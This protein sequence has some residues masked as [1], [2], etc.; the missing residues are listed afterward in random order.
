MDPRRKVAIGL[1]GSVLDAGK[2]T[3]RWEKWRPTVA[4]CQYE[5][6]VFDRLELLYQPRFTAIFEQL[7]EDIR[8][9]SPE[10]TVRGHVITCE[11][12]WDFQ[13]VYTCLHDFA[14]AYP[15]DVDH[16]E[17]FVHITTGTHVAQIC[18]SLLTEAR[19]FPAKLFQAS[20]PPR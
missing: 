9:V 10:T 1:V 12:P 15:F 7:V 16:E 19:Y 20:P 17:Y 11:D 14:R 4:I 5:D 8:R 2:G 18:L 13:D 6:W 3:E